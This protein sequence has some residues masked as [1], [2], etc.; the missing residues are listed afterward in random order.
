MKPPCR[1]HGYGCLGGDL[2][3]TGQAKMKKI[4]DKE[5]ARVM[6]WLTEKLI[7]PLC[8]YNYNLERIR[9]IP[10]SSKASDVTIHTNCGSCACELLFAVD[11]R[12][13][14]VFLVGVVTDLTP[15]DVVKFQRMASIGADE[16]IDS[17]FFWKDF[18]GDFYE[19]F[20]KIRP[21]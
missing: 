21:N 15:Q 17:H 20:S 8:S 16:V 13:G 5:L 9:V 6:A 4:P 12:E 14:E 7:C 11:I 19:L 18:S 3:L 10:R 2:L 1:R